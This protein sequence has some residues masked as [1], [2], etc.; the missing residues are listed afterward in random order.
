MAGC[1]RFDLTL[2]RTP[3]GALSFGEVEASSPDPFLSLPGLVRFSLGASSP[4][5]SVCDVECLKNR[6]HVLSPSFG[7][8]SSATLLVGI[9]LL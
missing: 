1:A 5:M 4:G 2:S 9:R 8:L 3:R 7:D 6:C